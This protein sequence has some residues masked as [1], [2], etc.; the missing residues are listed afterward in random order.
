MDQGG[1]GGPGGPEPPLVDQEWVLH[2]A[3]AVRRP[4]RKCLPSYISDK[5]HKIK[6]PLDSGSNMFLLNQNTARTLKVHYEIT[7]N[8]L[9]ITAFNCQI[10]FTGGKYYPHPIQLEIGT[11]CY[12]PLL[13]G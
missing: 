7:E 3:D 2:F 9:K 11:N 5:L 4:R 12:N 6:V 13:S 8:P 1:P 10:S